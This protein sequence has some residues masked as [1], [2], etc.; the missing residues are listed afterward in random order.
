M[1][2]QILYEDNHILAAVKPHMMPSQE[3][4]SGDMD[5]LTAMKRYIRDKY[6]KPGEVYLALV[7]RLD[8]PTGGVMIFARTSKAAARLCGQMQRGEMVKRYYAVVH[9]APPASGIL[10]DRLLK[11]SRT[12][13]VRTVSQG[14]KAAKLEYAVI[15][16][17]NALSLADIRLYTGRSHQIRVQFASRGWPLYGDARYGHAEGEHIALFAYSLTFTHPTTQQ[18][19]ELRA[20]PSGAPFSL[21]SLPEVPRAGDM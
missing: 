19:I 13:M 17:A 5:M 8:R 7:H 16:R 12:N 3:D 1:N 4:A 20:M 14:G 11:D 15:G 9:G 10:E 6:H 21:F 18:R 2:M